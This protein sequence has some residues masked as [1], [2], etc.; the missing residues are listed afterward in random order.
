MN[1]LLDKPD[2]FDGFRKG[3][4]ES[5]RHYFHLHHYTIYCYLL[6]L[7]REKRLAQELTKNSFVV[8]IRM[9]A[10]VREE[11]HLLRYLY[12]LARVAY[13]LH[14]RQK[15]SV[16]NLAE[17]FAFF[18]ID[19]PNIMEDPD[20]VRNETLISMQAALQKLPP[21][22]KEVAEL[23]FFQGLTI[24]K[25]ADY[26]RVSDGMAK[27]QVSEIIRWLGDELSRNC[28][29]RNAFWRASPVR[30]MDMV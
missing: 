30:G 17:E 23:Y 29:D 28:G 2:Y 6:S 12:L 11:E 22:T 7:I 20:V 8:L 18:S 16:Q 27:E 21:Q 1:H 25:I 24:R 15:C 14:R 9:K 5:F 3:S 13:L 10:Q 26:L 19:D 4:S